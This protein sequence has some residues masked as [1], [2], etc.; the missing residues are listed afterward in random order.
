MQDKHLGDTDD[1]D[2]ILSIFG[3]LFVE[4]V[5]KVYTVL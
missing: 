4:M 2:D 5:F 1:M 3:G